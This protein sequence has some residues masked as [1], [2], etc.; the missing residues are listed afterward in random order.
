MIKEFNLNI[1]IIEGDIIR[2]KNGLA[3]SS[4]NSHLSSNAKL[5]AANI[6]KLL[7]KTAD[8]IALNNDYEE[9]VKE[10]ANYFIKND[11]VLDYLELVDV[12]NFKSPNKYSKKL[13]LLVAAYVEN[14]RL[15]D[16]L[17][18]KL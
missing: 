15:I 5:K 17:D 2:D 16:N 9:A 8:T 7:L 14:V 11:I 6:Y 18:I 12:E 10:G 13:K 3:L 4:R 1:H